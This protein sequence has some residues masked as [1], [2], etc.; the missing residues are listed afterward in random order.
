MHYVLFKKGFQTWEYSPQYAIRSYAYLWIH[1][2]PLKIIHFLFGANK[3]FICWH[4][5]LSNC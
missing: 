5:K 4:L 2:F 3:V 1:G